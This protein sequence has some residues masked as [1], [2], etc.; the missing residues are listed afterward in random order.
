DL[1]ERAEKTTFP[2][3]RGRTFY[4]PDIQLQAALRG[5]ARAIEQLPELERPRIAAVEGSEATIEAFRRLT[6]TFFD[7]L[8]FNFS[9]SIDTPRTQETAAAPGPGGEVAL[10]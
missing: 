2:D 4:C 8:T 10:A 7:L 5:V 9:P 3:G 6:T 1:S